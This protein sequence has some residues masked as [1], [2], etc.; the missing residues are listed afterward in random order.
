MK[1]QFINENLNGEVVGYHTT[2]EN[3]SSLI[4]API[5]LAPSMELAKAYYQNF[6]DDTD[7]APNIFEITIHGKILQEDEIETLCE[8]LDIDYYDL[9][10]AL[11]SNPDVDEANQLVA[12][13]KPICDGFYMSDYDPRDSQSDVD[14]ICVINQLTS[15]KNIKKIK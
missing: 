11:V 6:L 10:V 7:D 15:I 4:D 12:P 9:N 2:Y 14:S 1:A 3:L 5:W 8:K 13:F